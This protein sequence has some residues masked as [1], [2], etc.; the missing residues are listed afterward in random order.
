MKGPR[1]I[2]YG[3][4]CGKRFSTTAEIIEI[5]QSVTDRNTRK[6]RRRPSKKRDIESTAA[7]PEEAGSSKHWHKRN[8]RRRNKGSERQKEHNQSKNN[9]Y[10]K[11]DKRTDK[12]ERD[13]PKLSKDEQERH[14]AEGLC[15]ICHKLGHFSRNCPERQKISS[16][17][18][19]GVSSFGVDVDFG[20]VERQR[21]AGLLSTW[22]T[23]S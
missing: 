21:Q 22:M 6:I 17:K 5:A 13:T 20:D 12:S 7:S 4:D 11:R 18:P 8:R 15:F 9:Q 1:S 3:L 2:S 14:K 16:S 23:I 19:P 10:K